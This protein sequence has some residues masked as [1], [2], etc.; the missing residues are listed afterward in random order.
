MK[1]LRIIVPNESA[2]DSYLADVGFIYDKVIRSSSTTCYKINVTD[3]MSFITF[4]LS[5]FRLNDYSIYCFFDSFV[6]RV[7]S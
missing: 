7:R 3:K 5:K 6:F 4:L 1:R 2:L